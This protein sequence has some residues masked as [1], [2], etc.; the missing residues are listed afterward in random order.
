MPN[1]IS[2]LSQ[3]PEAEVGTASRIGITDVTHALIL[4]YSIFRKM[5]GQERVSVIHGGTCILFR[6]NLIA[7]NARKQATISHSSTEVEYKVVAN[8]TT[9]TILV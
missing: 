6:P 7:W 2:I 9:E 4:F 8:A 1:P 5:D 3:D